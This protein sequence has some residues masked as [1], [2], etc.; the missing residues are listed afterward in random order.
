[1]RTI[2]DCIPT[3]TR[4]QATRTSNDESGGSGLLPVQWTCQCAVLCPDCFYFHPSCN[5]P[6]YPST[7]RSECD[8]SLVTLEDLM[9][10]RAA[11]LCG[12]YAMAPTEPSAG[13]STATLSWPC[14]QSRLSPGPERRLFRGTEDFLDFRTVGTIQFSVEAQNKRLKCLVYTAKWS[15]AVV[16]SVL[17]DS[18]SCKLRGL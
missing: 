7:R 4:F 16:A 11:W 3:K 12:L 13:N 9:H 18:G 6:A 10:C 17:V 15:L 2:L 5:V 14:S 1:M 8:G